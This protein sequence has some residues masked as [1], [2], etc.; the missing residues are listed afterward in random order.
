[1]YVHVI[2]NNLTCNLLQVGIIVRVSFLS[3]D[4]VVISHILAF[5]VGE[6]I[7]MYHILG[8]RGLLLSAVLATVQLLSIGCRCM[9]VPCLQ[10]RCFTNRAHCQF[11]LRFVTIHHSELIVP[12]IY[13]CSSRSNKNCKSSLFPILRNICGQVNRRQTTVESL[14]LTY[15]L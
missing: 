11:F 4:S 9:S 1:M 12:Q 3:F 14:W 13:P 2:T 5:C 8:R 7:L 10:F 6:Y 15:M